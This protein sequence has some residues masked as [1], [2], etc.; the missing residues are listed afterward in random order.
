MNQSH[1]QY[2][3]ISLG[4]TL[5][6]H[7]TCFRVWS[8]SASYVYLNIY[9]RC[10]DYR[11][12]SYP[13]KKGE[14]NVWFLEIPENLEGH[15]YTYTVDHYGTNHEIVDP[16]AV[17][18]SPNS[19]RGYI[20]D[21]EKTNPKGW[22]QGKR[23]EV[24]LMDTVIYETH[25][26][27]LTVKWHDTDQLQGTFNGVTKPLLK[28]IKDLG[29]TH[30]QWMPVFDFATVDELG[31]GYNWGYDPKL[32]N[33]VEGSYASSVYDPTIRITELKEMIQRCHHVGLRVIMDVVYNHTYQSKDANLNRLGRNYFY[34]MS[35]KNRFSNGSGCGN[36]LAT[37][38]K[39][40]RKFI[41]DSL[42][43][44][45]KEFKIDGFRFDLMGLYDVETVELIEKSLKAVDPEVLLYGEPWTAGGSA[46]PY[47]QQFRK[48]ILKGGHVGYFND[49][50]RKSVKG[51]NDSGSRG[52]IGG[53][54]DTKVLLNT[55][56]GSPLD[57]KKHVGYTLYP[58]ESINYLTSHDNLNLFDKIS[59]SF[60]NA[61]Y[62]TKKKI[63]GLCFSILFTSVGIPF[64]QGGAEMMVSKQGHHNT[65]N[66]GDDINAYDWSLAD[67]NKDLRRYIKRIIAFRRE[68]FL[69]QLKDFEE[70]K[71]SCHLFI[72]QKGIIEMTIQNSK[73]ATHIVIYHNGSEQVHE[74]ILPEG[75]Y[76][77]ICDGQCFSEENGEKI[78]EKTIMLPAYQTVI[79]KK[80]I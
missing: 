72:D 3:N 76:I 22:G 74:E 52:Y 14:N 18:S 25:V 10:Q 8:F 71:A 32:F 4:V 36:E 37:E 56:L 43:Y 28:K 62:E 33:V 41:I 2:D 54:T 12:K 13:M 63:C 44:W 80:K 15:Y 24:R 49:D 79:L 69:Y 42:L 5:R 67:F 7:Q 48:G 31:E 35:G 21:L 23:P 51:D 39:M 38:N 77:V 6:G 20:I 1:F 16:Y 11:R 68:T 70:I 59:R 26:R 65:Y 47:D 66:M 61:P 34:R 17:A 57:T 78:V 40:V 64:I 30:I 19:K 45:Q 29:V 58:W 75:I 9:D 53:L 55:L 73:Y 27:D 60:P 50:F 46:L